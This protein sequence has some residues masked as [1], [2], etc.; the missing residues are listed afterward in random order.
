MRLVNGNLLE[1]STEE[2]KKKKQ[3]EL[4]KDPEKAAVWI[5]R[6]KKLKI[7]RVGPSDS[8]RGR[9]RERRDDES[10]AH[11]A[12][13]GSSS[14][15]DVKIKKK[16]ARKIQGKK[17]LGNFWPVKQLQAHFKNKADGK[18]P[19]IKKVMWY[20]GQKGALLDLCHGT[21][22][23]T[24]V[25]HEIIED[26]IDISECIAKSSKLED[27]STI[28]SLWREVQGQKQLKVLKP[29][30]INK[31]EGAP[32][33]FNLATRSQPEV[34]TDR[35]RNFFEHLWGGSMLTPFSKEKKS[36]V[37]EWDD[38]SSQTSI[39]V[40]EKDG[41][42]KLS[43]YDQTMAEFQ[44]FI[45][46]V[47]DW[48]ARSIID[49]STFMQLADGSQAKEFRT[50]A[51][52]MKSSISIK[53]LTAATLDAEAKEAGK[54][55]FEKF[56]TT[57]SKL[58][59]MG[60]LGEFV[61]E[62]RKEVKEDADDE[63]D[64]GVSV[65]QCTV[66][67]D[68]LAASGIKIERSLLL[69]ASLQRFCMWILLLRCD[70]ASTEARAEMCVTALNVDDD[71]VS[72]NLNINIFAVE[73]RPKTQHDLL[74][75]CV[76]SLF[77]KVGYERMATCFIRMVAGKAGGGYVRTQSLGDTFVNELSVLVGPDQY[78]KDV[79]ATATTSIRNPAHVFHRAAINGESGKKI[80]ALCDMRR[81]NAGRDA[82]SLEKLI[83]VVLNDIFVLGLAD[84]LAVPDPQGSSA[85]V[86]AV[87]TFEKNTTPK[88]REA[89]KELADRKD[90]LQKQQSA[91]V[92]AL[93]LFHTRDL[94]A[95]VGQL[96]EAAPSLDQVRKLKGIVKAMKDAEPTAQGA[97][98]LHLALL[99]PDPCIKLYEDTR[100]EGFRQLDMVY[101]VTYTLADPAK[102]IF[103]V[104][105]K[106]IGCILDLEKSRTEALKPFI[107]ALCT[108]G[109]IR[110][111]DTI[112][113]LALPA[114]A[115]CYKLL[116]TGKDP[117]IP[118]CTCAFF[119]K[120][121]VNNEIFKDSSVNDIVS[122][123]NT[124]NPLVNRRKMVEV[125][126]Q[127]QKV[128]IFGV[129]LTMKLFPILRSF[130]QMATCT[131]K[132][133]QITTLRNQLQEFTDLGECHW[134]EGLMSDALRKKCLHYDTVLLGLHERWLK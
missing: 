33:A 23:G 68:T 87:K 94:L 106:S 91:M 43:K 119:Q 98:M 97:G 49:L 54:T 5:E 126:V 110:L 30:P 84:Q 111:K 99:N 69:A 128:E 66:M 56:N 114:F 92:D 71:V 3:D 50:R 63:D 109:Q 27:P 82:S 11:R 65:E 13:S 28:Q 125:K 118:N 102:S 17:C 95:L 88:F 52:P 75:L 15:E 134:N 133:E 96:A 10:C 103:T 121:E 131:N 34:P 101:N 48:I 108:Q 45:T 112:E 61:A 89:C 73:Q 41:D 85:I 29:Q 42:G 78:E 19:K 7:R 70:D 40:A 80:L 36:I 123:C 86:V 83:A 8:G 51:K 46:D 105:P 76:N 107:L 132:V 4:A 62:L 93:K 124:L 58:G 20:D 59:M 113:G 74:V 81:V 116:W 77:E 127:E 38:K 129:V 9:K 6:G 130:S 100:K 37:E 55:R 16:R 72:Q 24:T 26:G 18:I 31:D 47:D 32:L 14:V 53:V 57:T 64:A 35:K 1:F 120:L 122:V 21:P 67:T 25:L 90:H 60:I 22:V 44:T 2:A 79:V 115:S 117:V 39:E 104:D 12:S